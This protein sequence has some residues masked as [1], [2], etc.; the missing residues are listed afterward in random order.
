MGEVTFTLPEAP[1]EDYLRLVR[2]WRE[3]SRYMSAAITMGGAP[4]RS[5][6]RDEVTDL[7]DFV[8][9]ETVEAEARKALAEGL[10]TIQPALQ[11]DALLAS[12]ARATARRRMTWLTEMAKHGAPSYDPDLQPL[13]AEAQ[14]RNDEVLRAAGFEPD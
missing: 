8:A 9:P 13:V 10:P 12:R 1:P 6:G 2:W 4:Q 5:R 3:A 11:V 14:A 7:V